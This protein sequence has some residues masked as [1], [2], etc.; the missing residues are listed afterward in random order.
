MQKK[1]AILIVDDSALIVSRL[2]GLLEELP[3]THVVGH[4][5]NYDESVLALQQNKPDVI[6]LDINLPGKNGIEILKYIK[7]GFPKITVIMFS[8]QNSDYYRDICK[9]LGADHFVDKSKGFEQIPAIL[10]PL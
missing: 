6:I 8:N 7:T 9:Q 10:S 4:A 2:T 3:N 5:S 1:L